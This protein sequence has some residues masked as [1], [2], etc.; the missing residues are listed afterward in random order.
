MRTYMQVTRLYVH[1]YMHKVTFAAYLHLMFTQTLAHQQ[2]YIY[3]QIDANE[4]PQ[5]DHLRSR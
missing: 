2:I 3:I 1:A 5:H 4:K